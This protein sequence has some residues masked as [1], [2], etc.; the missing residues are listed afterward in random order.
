MNQ[1]R[2]AMAP[3]SIG[4]T[5]VF[6]LL[7]ALTAAAG[8]Q[9]LLGDGTGVRGGDVCVDVVPGD[10]VPDSGWRETAG[11][12]MGL[13]DGVHATAS[14]VVI[15]DEDPTPNLIAWQAL[16]VLPELLGL[17]AFLGWLIFLMRGMRRDGYFA[18]RMPA[19]V[20]RLGQFMIAWS[21]AAW[22]VSGFVKAVMLHQLTTTADTLVFSST[23]FPTVLVLV[24][25]GL[26]TL[27][28]VLEPAA[29]LRRESEATI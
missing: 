1:P 16:R 11:G 17:L 2:N 12:P 4:V 10:G 23:D 7:I 27:G 29:A 6:V 25:L 24:G 28:R 13:R 21:F 9:V 3:L 14:T 15:C 5:I 18:D 8:S 26:I 22:M 20:D 19:A